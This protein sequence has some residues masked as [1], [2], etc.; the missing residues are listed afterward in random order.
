ME[1]VK[2]KKKLTIAV[3]VKYLPKFLKSL[4][5]PLINCNIKLKLKWTNYCALPAACEDNENNRN[6]NFIFTINDTRLN[7]PVVT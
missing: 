1:M 4:E 7:V 5:M 3:P 2:F 6:D